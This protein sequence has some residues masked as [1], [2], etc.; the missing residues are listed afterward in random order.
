MLQND[1]KYNF[2][3]LGNTPEH[4][5]AKVGD[6]MIWESQREK[7]LGVTI[8]K[9]INFNGHLSIICKKIEF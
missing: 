6:S 5:W 2:L 7:L 9:K 1:R 4:L 8:D 3:F